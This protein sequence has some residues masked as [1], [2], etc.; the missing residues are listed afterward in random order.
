MKTTLIIGA[1]SNAD[2]QM[3]KTG[4]NKE[5]DIKPINMPTGEELVRK[6]EEFGN[7]IIDFCLPK[8]FCESINKLNYPD[9]LE[10]LRTLDRKKNI[11]ARFGNLPIK[12]YIHLS[13]LIYKYDPVSIDNFLA[14]IND[15]KIDIKSSIKIEGNE[16]EKEIRENLI[17][18]GKELIAFIL[19]I[20]EDDE[21]FTSQN[22]IWYRW[23]Q[24]AILNCAP[25][26]DEI[27]QKIKDDFSIISFNYDRSLEFFLK[28]KLKPKIYQSIKK[29]IIYPYGSLNSDLTQRN[30]EYG[31]IKKIYDNYLY[32]LSNKANSFEAIGDL[33]LNENSFLKQIAQ[34]IRVVGERQNEV[35][36]DQFEKAKEY[37]GKSH[38][39]YLLGFGFIKENCEKLGFKEFS[40]NIRNLLYSSTHATMAGEYWYRNSVKLGE[41]SPISYTNFDNKSKVNDEFKSQFSLLLIKNN[42]GNFNS[43]YKLST[44]GVY[45]ALEGD[46]DL[47]L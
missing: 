30:E 18:A 27:C 41:F 32:S 47:F 11:V 23:L 34:N 2:F 35:C 20:H 36:K 17:K 42:D 4:E 14:Q 25:T 8:S 22:K 37:V 19:L 38:K 7:K 15:E 1:G 21:I 12:P 6:I 24:H 9:Y 40:K 3:R 39:L 13:D 31:A 10:Q 33:F 16:T 28:E 29:K 46:F 43:L 44:R 5:E 45:N 26:I